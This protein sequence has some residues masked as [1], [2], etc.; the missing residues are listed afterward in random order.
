MSKAILVV[1]MPKCCLDCPLCYMEEMFTY[2]CKVN[3]DQVQ[4]NEMYCDCPLKPM[5]QKKW[6]EENYEDEIEYWR[7]ESWNNCIDEILG[8]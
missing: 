5:P 4:A 6:H 7:K 3:D 1:D 8:E 2:R